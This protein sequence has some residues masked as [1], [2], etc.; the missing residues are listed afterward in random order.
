MFSAAFRNALRLATL[1]VALVGLP[2]AAEETRTRAEYTVTMGGTHIANVTI[3]LTDNG[4]QYALALDAKIAGLAQLIAS[5]SAKASSVGTSGR[6]GLHAQKFDLLTR[7]AGEEFTSA[8]TY[9]SG[10]VATFKVEPPIVDNI[11]RIAI[12]RKQLATAT[13]MMAPFVLRGPALDKSLCNK[14]MPIFTGVERFNL[15][16]KY[17]KDDTATSRRTGYQGPLVLCSVHYT[18][19]SGHYTYNE[20]TNYL[21]QNERILIWF[22]PLKLAGTY[23]PYRA[24]ITTEAGD[25]SVVLTDLTE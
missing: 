17:V 2:A 14:Q 19:I 7:A 5:G 25:L 20:I 11:D 13:D 4:S 21:A 1:A 16:L 6:D 15:S 23:I 8:I 22:A 18:P 24:L 9:A 10:S 12:E 3:I